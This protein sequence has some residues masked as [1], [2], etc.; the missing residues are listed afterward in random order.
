MEMTAAIFPFQILNL[1]QSIWNY[2]LRVYI[3]ATHT[4]KRMFFIAKLKKNSISVF[5]INCFCAQLLYLFNTFREI[6]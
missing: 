6:P 4:D 3:Y 5:A 1:L 2:F